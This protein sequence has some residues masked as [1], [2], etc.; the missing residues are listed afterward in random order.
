VPTWIVNGG[1][2]PPDNDQPWVDIQT[3]T[4]IDAWVGQITNEAVRTR[5]V[6]AVDEVMA[7]LSKVLPEGIELSRAGPS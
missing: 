3:V 6:S 7:E 2:P 5:L 4:V 1:T